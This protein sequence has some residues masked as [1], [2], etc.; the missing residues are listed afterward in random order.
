VAVRR[1]RIWWLGTWGAL[2]LL[3]TASA[4]WAEGTITPGLVDFGEQAVGT[5]SA[6][7]PIEL[8]NLGPGPF[9]VNGGELNSGP[10]NIDFVTTRDGCTGVTLAPGERCGVELAFTPTAAGATS[11]TFGFD[12][13]GPDYETLAE[14]VAVV[15]LNGIG[16]GTLPPVKAASAPLPEGLFIPVAGVVA[17][18]L[19]FFL[20]ASTRRGPTHG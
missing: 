19:G 14:R 2:A 4:G 16:T 12:V 5:Q 9:L 6:S 18:G 1:G 15:T 7:R 20:V 3:T 10:D 13:S 17:L 11:Q 8:V